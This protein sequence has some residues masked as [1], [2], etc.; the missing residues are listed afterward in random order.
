MSFLAALGNL[1]QYT[2]AP[3]K[4]MIGELMR[5]KEYGEIDFLRAFTQAEDTGSAQPEAWREA[6]LESQMPLTMEEK[7]LLAD[8]ADVLGAAEIQSQLQG[9][10]LCRILLNEHLIQ[11]KE[12][13]D[14]H[15]KLYRTLGALAGAL[16]AIILM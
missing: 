10:E 3:V 4:W 15:S 7:K 12:Y 5:R 9:I 16:A 6:V 13:R 1:L 11:A 14:K 8:L 2:R